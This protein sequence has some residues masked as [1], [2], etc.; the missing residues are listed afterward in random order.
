MLI[1][2]SEFITTTL[3]SKSFKLGERIDSKEIC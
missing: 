3:R 2:V 1:Q